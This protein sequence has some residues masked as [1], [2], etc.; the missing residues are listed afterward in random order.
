M[1]KSLMWVLSVLMGLAGC[2]PAAVSQPTITY[3]P[4]NTPA[5]AP[6]ITPA[7]ITYSPAKTPTPPPVITPAAN[8]IIITSNTTVTTAPVQAPMEEPVAARAMVQVWGSNAT[9]N[10][11]KKMLSFGVGVGDGS[12]VLTFIDFENFTPGAMEIVTRNQAR[13]GVTIQVVDAYT[14]VTLLKLNGA[15]RVAAAAVSQP[16]LP[17]QGQQVRIWGWLDTAFGY[18]NLQVV[19]DTSRPIFFRTEHDIVLG[20]PYVDYPGALVTDNAGNILGLETVFRTR[21]VIL[22]GPIG[23]MPPIASIG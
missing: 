11:L 18:S 10:P 5:A 20:G 14:G 23:K 3:T 17:A 22:L 1:K 13:Y 9:G 12:Q 21:L 2:A 4:S 6:V 15:G 8:P 19:Y 16:A 7:T